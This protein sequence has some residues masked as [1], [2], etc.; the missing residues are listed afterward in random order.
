MTIKI[1]T[2]KKNIKSKK[3]RLNGKRNYNKKTQKGGVFSLKR[4]FKRSG[5]Y[6]TRTGIPLVSEAPNKAPIRTIVHPQ[7]TPNALHLQRIAGID[8]RIISNNEKFLKIYQ[9]ILKNKHSKQN[10]IGLG[11]DLKRHLLKLSAEKNLKIN[12][13]YTTKN[14]ITALEAKINRERAKENKSFSEFTQ[15][16]TSQI[17]NTESTA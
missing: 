7:L 14:M 3:T 6:S 1:K 2:K 15:S 13:A 10:N 5:S 17:L 16:L 9:N 11:R 12:G 4:L 8:P